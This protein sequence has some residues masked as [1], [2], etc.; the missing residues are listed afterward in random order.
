MSL[1][2]N[3]GTAIVRLRLMSDARSAIEWANGSAVQPWP[4][5]AEEVVSVRVPPGN[6]TF[7]EF[8]V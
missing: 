3:G 4:L 8:S 7:V 6:T 2:A 5:K 1:D